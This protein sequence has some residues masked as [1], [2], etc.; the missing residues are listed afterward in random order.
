MASRNTQFEPSILLVEDDP[1]T[2]QQLADLLSGHFHEL[3]FAENGEQGLRM[4]QERK[5][6]IVITDILMPVMNGLDMAGRIRKLNPAARIVIMTAHSEI[7]NSA[8]A[9]QVADNYV[10][11]PIDVDALVEIVNRCKDTILAEKAD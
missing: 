3:H 4:Y 10:L 8:D 11:K 7:A 9:R 2:R 6:D 5:H 1:L